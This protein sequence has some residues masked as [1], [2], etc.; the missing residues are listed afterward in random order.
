MED[1]G[2]NEVYM[3][4][5]GS[6]LAQ[7]LPGSSFDP[8]K[9]GAMI[10]N[11]AANKKKAGEEAKKKAITDFDKTLESARSDWDVDQVE[12]FD[13][14]VKDMRQRM[15]QK[16]AEGNGQI[17]NVDWI[18]FKNEADQKVG[19]AA[20][21]KS[22]FK[23]WE[24][25]A[26]KLKGAKPGVYDEQSQTD[27]LFYHSPE[28]YRSAMVTGPNGELIS[29]E[30]LIASAKDE[31]GKINRFKLRAS[32]PQ[33]LNIDEKYNIESAFF[34]KKIAGDKKKSTSI[35]EA[36]V[37]STPGIMT[38]TVEEYTPTQAYSEAMGEMASQPQFAKIVRTTYLPKHLKDPDFISRA[39]QNAGIQVDINNKDAVAEVL[40][41]KK[42]IDALTVQAGADELLSRQEKQ[43]TKGFSQKT[44]GSGEGDGDGLSSDEYISNITDG[45]FYVGVKRQNGTTTDTPV[46]NKGQFSFTPTKVT[47]SNSTGLVNKKTNEDIK[48]PEVR[49]FTIGQLVIVPVYRSGPLKGKVVPDKFIQDNPGLAN[50]PKVGSMIEYKVVA[51]GKYQQPQK[52]DLN[53]G[54]I[55]INIGEQKEDVPVYMPLEDVEF[56]LTQ[57]GSKAY[58]NAIKS[59]IMD[60]KNRVNEL[61]NMIPSYKY[62]EGDAQTKGKAR[63]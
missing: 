6:G 17:S 55:S 52:K 43:V 37:G 38:T 19:E 35:S 31:N 62:G 7:V 45:A 32:N 2:L 39:F 47:L 23:Q 54:N 60:F 46:T 4:R 15:A 27:L 18:K 28:K 26:K 40:K 24:E 13:G 11:I 51:E 21:S 8:T 22:Q 14:A 20:A 1:L 5:E 36:N 30:E 25:S 58:R 12:Y 44:K 41:T 49:D 10:L 16:M 48:S 29:G 57:K 59:R 61:N 34:N 53:S 42:G 9:A 50:S 3:G 56:A 33:L 63:G